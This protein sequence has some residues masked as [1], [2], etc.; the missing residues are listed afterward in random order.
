MQ[1]LF[2]YLQSE[3][4]AA[5]NIGFYV[6]IGHGFFNWTHPCCGVLHLMQNT[7]CDVT[8]RGVAS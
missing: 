1:C 5:T 2:K 6:K 4:P 7:C 8:D 3:P